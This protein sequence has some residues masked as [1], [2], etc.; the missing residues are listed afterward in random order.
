MECTCGTWVLEG[1]YGT[2]TDPKSEGLCGKHVSGR[3]E[4][5]TRQRDHDQR[6]STK[7]VSSRQHRR[8]K[9]DWD[10]RKSHVFKTLS[11]RKRSRPKDSSMVSFPKKNV[12]RGF[13]Y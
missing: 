6:T 3:S 12:T 1:Y 10:P 2:T 9:R 13:P 5:E 4:L 8:I 7:E 11:C